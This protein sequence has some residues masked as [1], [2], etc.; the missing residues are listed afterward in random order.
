M[1]FL[2]DQTE[3]RSSLSTLPSPPTEASE[4]Q[5]GPSIQEEVEEPSLRQ[6][7]LSQ[8][9]GLECGSQEVAGGSGSQEVAGSSGLTQSKVPTLCLPPKGPGRGGMW[10]RQHLPSFRMFMRP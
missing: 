9:E 5:P 6:E 3:V 8:N 10:M 2:K 4:D 7:S 1:H